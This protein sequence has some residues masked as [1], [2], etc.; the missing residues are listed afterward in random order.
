[1]N[2]RA[3]RFAGNSQQQLIESR[4]NETV[5]LIDKQA[6]VHTIAR[7]ALAEVYALSLSIAALDSQARGDG[8]HVNSVSTVLEP[9][10]GRLMVMLDALVDK[11]P[12]TDKPALK[13]VA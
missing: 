2:N 11:C 7:A 6:S 8:L 12:A 5:F 1:M 13:V 10:S 4:M 3:S 9:I